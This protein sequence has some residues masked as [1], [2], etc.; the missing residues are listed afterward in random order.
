MEEPKKMT[1][2]IQRIAEQMGLDKQRL[3][4]IVFGKLPT[5]GPGK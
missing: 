4:E 5:V 1:L 3:M 2:D